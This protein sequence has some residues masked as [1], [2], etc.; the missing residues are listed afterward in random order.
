MDPA[1]GFLPI[2]MIL[3]IR[4]IADPTYWN[5]EFMLFRKRFRGIKTF[6]EKHNSFYYSGSVSF[7]VLLYTLIACCEE[8]SCNWLIDNEVLAYLGLQKI[9]CEFIRIKL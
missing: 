1:Y 6:P 7:F 8:E 3:Y 4:P 9:N 5:V 2:L